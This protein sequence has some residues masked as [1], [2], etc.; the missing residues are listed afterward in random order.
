M[1]KRAK[2]RKR[3]RETSYR[4]VLYSTIPYIHFIS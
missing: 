4:K 3:G 1:K 2:E